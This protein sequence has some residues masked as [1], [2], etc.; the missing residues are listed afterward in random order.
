LKAIRKEILANGL[1]NFKA[2][3]TGD[4]LSFYIFGEKIGYPEIVFLFRQM[5]HPSVNSLASLSHLKKDSSLSNLGIKYILSI[6]DLR[7]P[8]ENFDILDFGKLSRDA[9]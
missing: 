9:E 6:N 8:H 1:S 2:Q 4:K 3:G 5:N 7:K